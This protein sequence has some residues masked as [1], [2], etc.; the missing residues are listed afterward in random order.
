MDKARQNCLWNMLLEKNKL[1]RIETN[2]RMGE[3]K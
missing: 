1:G 2:H 3:R